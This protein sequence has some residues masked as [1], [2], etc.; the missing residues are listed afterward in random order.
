MSLVDYYPVGI[1]RGFNIIFPDVAVLIPQLQIFTAVFYFIN[2][3]WFWLVDKS[4]KLSRLKS[5]PISLL[6]IRPLLFNETTFE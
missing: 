2:R 1:G 6:K 3:P 5:V 4:N